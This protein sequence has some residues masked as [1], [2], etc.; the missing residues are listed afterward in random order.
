MSK[1][2][3]RRTVKQIMREAG[4]KLGSGPSDFLPMSCRASDKERDKARRD[5]MKRCPYLFPPKKKEL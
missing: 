4:L 3:R 1:V 2:S 5:L